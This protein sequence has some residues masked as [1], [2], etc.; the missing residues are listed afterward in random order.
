MCDLKKK[1]IRVVTPNNVLE[2]GSFGN[3]SGTIFNVADKNAYGCD[4][5]K[6][7]NG[8]FSQD[9][10]KIDQTSFSHPT[11]IDGVLSVFGRGTRPDGKGAKW[12]AS[13]RIMHR[14]IPYAL[15]YDL[16]DAGVIFWHQATYLKDLMAKAMNCQLEVI[17]LPGTVNNPKGNRFGTLRIAKVLGHTDKNVLKAQDYVFNFMVSS[18]VWTKILN[19]HELVDPSPN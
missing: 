6:L 9:I 16:A 15:C 8:I 7:F 5:E 12:V 1:A 10:S 19:D 13:S 4:A 14:D 18:P 2:P 11:N 3:F 17:S